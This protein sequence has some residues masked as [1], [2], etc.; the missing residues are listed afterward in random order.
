M[1]NAVGLSRNVAL[2]VDH[3]D[4]RSCVR[5]LVGL[6]LPYVPVLSGQELMPELESRIAGEAELDWYSWF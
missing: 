1:R 5:A 4:L 6:E 2:I 3:E